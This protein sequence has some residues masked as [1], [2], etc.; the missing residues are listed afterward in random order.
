MRQRDHVIELI[1]DDEIVQ[2][3]IVRNKKHRKTLL[4]RWRHMYGQKFYL[5][6][7]FEYMHPK[8]FAKKK[9]GRPADIL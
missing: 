7:I 4:H 5:L 6:S 9:T 8:Q 3:C 1:R 2:H